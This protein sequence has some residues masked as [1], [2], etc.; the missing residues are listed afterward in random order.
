MQLLQTYRSLPRPLSIP[1]P[2]YPPNSVVECLLKIPFKWESSTA[3]FIEHEILMYK[4]LARKL[5]RIDLIVNVLSLTFLLILR[6]CEHNF[7]H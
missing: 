2:S 1:K 7:L 3:Y 4:L 5:A 6:T